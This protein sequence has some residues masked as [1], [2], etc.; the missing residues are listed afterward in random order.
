MTNQDSSHHQVEVHINE[1]KVEILGDHP[2]GH[3]I[4][5]SAIEQG[6]DIHL[7]WML[8]RITPQGEHSVDDGEHVHIDALSVFQAHPREIE[9]F[10]NEKPVLISGHK[11][12]GL[13]IKEAA[14]RQGAPL[15]LDFILSEEFEPR[16][17]RVIGDE[18]VVHLHK[19][20]R[21]VAVAPDDNS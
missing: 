3:H 10:V 2:T 14:L 16:R 20:Q 7:E 21:F 8:V 18:D 1:A 5:A 17:T 13:E 12:T 4:K 19:H 6:V 9:I 15:Q 11:A